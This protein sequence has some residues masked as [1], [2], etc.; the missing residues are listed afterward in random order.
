MLPQ[1]L[2]NMTNKSTQFFF[3]KY[4]LLIL[5]LLA[6]PSSLL[7]FAQ[8]IAPKRLP[9][10]KIC[11][12]GPH[13]TIAGSVFNEYQAAFSILG[14]ASDVTFEVIL[15]DASG[16]FTT[17][18]ATTALAPLAGT[19]PD[20]ATDK[21]LT[22]AIPTSLIGSDTYQL[23]VKSSTG[24]VSSSFTINGTTSTKSFPAYFK[25]YNGSFSIN[26]DQPT[27]TFC[28]GG[29]IDLT[30]YNPTPGTPSSSPANYSQLKYIWYKDDVVISGQTSSTL[31]V[32]AAG[33]YYAKINYGPCTDDNFRSQS[34][35][36][37][38]SAGSTSV[39]ASSLGNPFCSSL[40]KT[41]LTATSGN[42]YVWKKD[43]VILTG[44]TTQNYLTDIAGLYTCEVD[45]GGCKSTGTVDLKVDQI[46]ST[47]SAD[48]DKINYA[49]IG[50][51]FVV[52]TTTTALAPSYQW[53]ENDV[54]I[55]TATQ[56]SLDITTSGKY[57]AIITQT[58]GCQSTSEFLFDVSFKDAPNVAFIPNIISPNGD[59]I[60]DTWIVPV[61]YTN[62]LANIMIL[63]SVG[64]NVFQT[65]NYDNN[66]G[67][68]QTPIE[69]TNFNPVYY[70]IIT[71]TD[72]SVKKGSI[73]LVK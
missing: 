22:F 8:T 38:S 19:P 31:T 10:D 33:D 18:T 2:F 17:P 13:P 70:Y 37:S 9:F 3:S 58:T 25:V 72:G 57:K 34:V 28:N 67:W 40:G 49:P 60:N 52:T 20:T 24:I 44:V 35:A 71:P 47:I 55:A 30:I 54:L 69:F 61:A 12:G 46:T 42:S 6:L 48:T 62:G 36:V 39:I 43:N 51:T 56:S 41:T 73:T 65:D 23:R 32:N 50:E 27:A 66:N 1:M 68:P 7:L 59:G 53:F 15:S 11:A 14:F 64:K 5:M 26:N 21:T 63:S 45:F 29:S 4:C 16:S